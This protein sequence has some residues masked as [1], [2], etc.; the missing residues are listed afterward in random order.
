MDFKSLKL[1]S[2]NGSKKI[3]EDLAISRIEITTITLGYMLEANK[4]LKN[5]KMNYLL[6]VIYLI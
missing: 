2:Q 6:T 5:I 3:Q 1:L 4:A